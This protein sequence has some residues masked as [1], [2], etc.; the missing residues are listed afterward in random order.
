MKP[1]FIETVSCGNWQFHYCLLNEPSDF[2]K[3][4]NVFPQ[5]TPFIEESALLT[6]TNYLHVTNDFIASEKNC[7]I[8]SFHYITK[9]SSQSNL[10]AH[11][12]VDQYQLLLTDL[13]IPDLTGHSL[14]TTVAI[15]KS[16]ETPI[17]ALYF[18]LT[19]TLNPFLSEIDH[20]ERSVVTAEKRHYD[21][22]KQKQVQ[23]LFN[24]RSD[25]LRL[26]HLTLPLQEIKLA[27]EEIYTN[28]HLQKHA[29]HSFNKR[30]E[31]TTDLLNQYEKQ[32]SS[33]L[34]LSTTFASYRGNEIMNALT[35][36]TVLT[37]PV[38]VFGA[39]WGM[40]FRV[41]PELYLKYGYL[42][43]LLLILFFTG[44]VALWLYRKGWL[45]NKKNKK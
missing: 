40:N 42:Y 45:G 20:F 1:A 27:T 29:I 18:L 16:F 2:S 37:T 19:K 28:N 36:F 43:S 33:M 4:A 11:F 32:L 26:R 7:M 12:Y 38:I 31:R 34:D 25:L 15:L 10:L 22:F 24:W 6:D 30:F 35:M 23:Q 21:K 5:Y 14:A 9:T 17:E 13:N 41:M 39:I 44:L 8:G 3:I